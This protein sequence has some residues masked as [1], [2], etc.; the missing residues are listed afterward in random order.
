MNSGMLSDNW[1]YWSYTP[2]FFES[3]NELFPF[4]L[5]DVSERLSHTT[6]YFGNDIQ[7]S[8][9]YQ[10]NDGQYR[11][12]WTL[13]KM[14]DFFAETILT[15]RST[16]TA[17]LNE[18]PTIDKIYDEGARLFETLSNLDRDIGQ[19]NLLLSFTDCFVS[20]AAYNKLASWYT[21]WSSDIPNIFT[22]MLRRGVKIHRIQSNVPFLFFCHAEYMKIIWWQQEHKYRFGFYFELGWDKTYHLVTQIPDWTPTPDWIYQHQQGKINKKIGRILL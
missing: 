8:P 15:H 12:P 5:W 13:Q 22:I 7:L 21:P 10:N 9:F 4:E 16:L 3:L 11:G 18:L 17:D 6:S 20:W 14:Q 2:Q 19:T 1:V